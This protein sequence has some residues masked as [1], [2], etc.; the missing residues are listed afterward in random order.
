MVD[1]VTGADG[2]MRREAIKLLFCG[3]LLFGMAAVWW[4][5]LGFLLYLALS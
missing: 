1:T 4:V 5:G 3:L 2:G